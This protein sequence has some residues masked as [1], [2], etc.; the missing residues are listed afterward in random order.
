MIYML[1]AHFLS[2]N[3][4]IFGKLALRYASPFLI[5]T[6][7]MLISSMLAWAC[8][9]FFI[10][11]KQNML[12]AFDVFLIFFLSIFYFYGKSIFM[13]WGIQYLPAGRASFILNLA[14][15]ITALLSFFIYGEVMTGKKYIGML[16]G[17]IGVGIV[18]V[19]TDS[20][21]ACAG[22]G[23][24]SWPEISVL[25]GVVAN[26]CGLLIIRYLVRVRKIPASI[27]NAIAMFF[28]S[29]F[30]YG[31][32]FVCSGWW[33]VEY[34]FLPQCAILIFTIAILHVLTVHLKSWLLKKYTAT[35]MAFTSFVMPLF[36]TL[37]EV[38]F[39]HERFTITFAAAFC[40]V[41]FG[42]YIFYL[43]E[44]RQGYVIQ[45]RK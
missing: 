10:Q 19:N 44:L 35:L 9:V 24:L 17:F 13:F 39:F 29:I 41:G 30:S 11:K 16:L 43:E 27:F 26:A 15:F 14:P 5:T 40:I 7:R 28:C 33:H 32:T 38:L 25:C 6:F 42:L 45:S 8:S 21:Y 20:S 37:F 4:L 2:A 12:R 1:F 36:V 23:F 3:I 31:T 34:A 18:L 22:Y